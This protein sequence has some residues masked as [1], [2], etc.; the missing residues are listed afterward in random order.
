MNE[1]LTVF[2]IGAISLGGYHLYTQNNTEE[3]DSSNGNGNG[4]GNGTPEVVNPLDNYMAYP[5]QSLYQSKVDGEFKGGLGLSDLRKPTDFKNTRGVENCAQWCNDNDDCKAFHV[6]D[7]NPE[8]FD[9]EETDPVQ[10]V[11]YYWSKDNSGLN[12]TN[13]SD[14]LGPGSEGKDPLSYKVDAYI[15]RGHNVITQ[16]A[17]AELMSHNPFITSQLN[18]MTW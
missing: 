14:G 2:L 12:H 18:Y 4:N 1:L 13:F 10:G 17:D 6:W 15:K 3:D 9:D 7:K 11:C 16:T 5:N 8:F